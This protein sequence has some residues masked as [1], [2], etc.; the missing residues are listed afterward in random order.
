MKLKI[1]ILSLQLSSGGLSD[2]LISL[3]IL[4]E[5]EVKNSLKWL[6]IIIGSV[7]TQLSTIMFAIDE[8][9]SDFLF[10]ADLIRSQDFLLLL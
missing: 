6:A 9:L 4:E 5:T 7:I 10:K 3:A 2:G 8:F 1:G